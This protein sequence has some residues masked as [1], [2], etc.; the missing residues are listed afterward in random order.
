MKTKPTK[1]AAK[2]APKLTPIIIKKAT[3]GGMGYTAIQ[4]ALFALP[5]SVLKERL[6]ERGLPIPKDKD[7]MITRLADWAIRAGGTFTLELR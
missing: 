7:T 4:D 5:T 6:R 1:S 2:K 3:R